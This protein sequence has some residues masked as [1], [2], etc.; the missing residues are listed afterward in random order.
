M[1]TPYGVKWDVIEC[2]VDYLTATARTKIARESLLQA[3]QRLSAAES[4][5]GNDTRPFAWMGYRGLCVG[6]VTWADRDDTSMLRLSGH[7][8]NAHWRTLGSA[9]ENCARIDIQ[10]TARCSE[11]PLW[12]SAK[13]YIDAMHAAEDA[14]HSGLVS[15]VTD[16]RGGWTVY[17]G[18]RTSPR[19]A[20]I[21]NKYAESRDELYRRCV[22]WEVEYKD[23]AANEFLRGLRG[24]SS[25][26][27]AILAT[28]SS[29]FRLRGAPIPWSAPGS[30][31][32]VSIQKTPTDDAI[33]TRWL[34]TQVRPTV[35]R[36]VVNGLLGKVVDALG[37]TAYVIV[38]PSP[39]DSDGT[40]TPKAA[41]N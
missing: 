37:L 12:M 16:N 14:N 25:T 21:Y 40:L 9:I 5:A 11:E 22:R 23:E 38:K 28:V 18:S 20:R 39:S 33:R 19:F 4:V 17:I 10:V 34:T 36:L 24:A 1:N 41:Q 15:H 6:P 30:P 29:H 32:P 2:G 26:Q 13:S 27:S 35:G 8:A 7:L 3:G 31:V